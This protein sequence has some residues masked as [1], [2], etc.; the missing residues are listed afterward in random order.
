MQRLSAGQ[1]LIGVPATLGLAIAI[2]TRDRGVQAVKRVRQLDREVGA[3]CKDDAGI[4]HAS[5]CIAATNALGTDAVFR[6]VHVTCGVR[7]L[8]GSNDAEVGK[9]LDVLEGHDLR[10]FDAIAQG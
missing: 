9:T 2:L 5:P 3:V 6:H 7:R 8:H 10:V 1:R 4:E